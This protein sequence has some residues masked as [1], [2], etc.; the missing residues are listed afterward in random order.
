MNGPEIMMSV[1]ADLERQLYSHQPQHPASIPTTISPGVAVALLQKAVRRALPDLALAAAHTLLRAAP[2]RLWR[3]LSIIAIEDVGLGDLDAVY[4]TIVASAHWR[5]LARRFGDK[6]LV[7]LVVSRLAA[8]PKCRSTD[9]LFVVTADCPTWDRVHLEL[10]DAQFGDLLNI[11][12]SDEPIERRAIALR[13][14]MGATTVAGGTRRKYRRADAVF[15]FMCEA[16][17]PHTLV[18]ISRTAYRQTGEVIA[19][20]LPT[21]HRDF[22]CGEAELAS[23]AFPP[24][25]TVG[26]LPSWCLDGFSREGRRAL[27]YFLNTGCQAAR[28]MR[29]NVPPGD[30]MTA[31]RHA[32]FRTEA[33]L[34]TDRLIWPTGQ[35]LRRQA[36]L[37]SWPFTPEDAATLLTLMRADIATL[38]DAREMTHGR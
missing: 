14:A 20:F 25:T 21:L 10:A 3:R 34:V 22:D 38:N 35:N 36:D 2:D 9:D 13:L 32:Q 11:V 6:R 24:E 30:R 33:G 28:W 7:N 31:L 18:E 16:G 1:A 17:F 29:A 5:R 15:D 8:A 19:A 4:L 23:D 27:T 26:G 12:A 37:D